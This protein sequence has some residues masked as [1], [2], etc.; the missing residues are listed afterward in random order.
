MPHIETAR[1]GLWVADHRQPGQAPVL[2]IHGAGGSHL[3]WG[4]PIRKLSSLAVDLN[5]HGRSA[6]AGHLTLAD[7]A[8]D[9]VA[10]L[11]ALDIDQ[12]TLVGHSMGGGIALTLALTYPERVARLVLVSTG[13]RL[14]VHPDILANIESD[15]GAV[16]DRLSAWLWG[17]D[18]DDAARQ[19]G[20]RQFLA[21]SPSVTARDY[22]AC[23]AF[24]VRDRLG[25]IHTPALVLCGTADVMTPPKFS[26]YLTANLPNAQLELFDGAGHMLQIERA[27]EVAAAITRFCAL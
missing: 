19:Q 14:K 27:A 21:L 17:A 12:I 6:G 1:G 26:E 13:A 5:G 25:D 3:D 20:K 16:A 9:L 4:M 24:D 23:D 2:L 10:L 22:H 7:H 15:T 11:D 18:V 8:A